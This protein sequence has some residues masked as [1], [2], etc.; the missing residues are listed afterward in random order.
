MFPVGGEESR[1]VGGV[2][3][4]EA[5]L[6]A[7]PCREAFASGPLEEP[8]LG[9]SLDLSLEGMR[10]VGVSA[11]RPHAGGDKGH[12][13][14]HLCRHG[15]APALVLRGSDAVTPSQSLHTGP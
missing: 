11:T 5:A 3:F 15:Y 4:G 8:R 9:V 12:V 1:R 2:K 6:P 10:G 14:P 7:H 13:C